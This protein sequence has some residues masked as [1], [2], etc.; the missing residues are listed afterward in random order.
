M[1]T[2]APIEIRMQDLIDQNE[3]RELIYRYCRSIDRC[4]KQALRSFYHPDAIEKHGVF[5][6]NALEFCD[7]VIEALSS[8]ERCMHCVSNIIINIDGDTANAESYV[9]GY[10]F[11]KK[12]DDSIHEMVIAGRYLDQ[13]QRRD[14]EWKFSE[15]LYVMD[16]NRNQAATAEWD[17]GIFA[18]L[19]TRG[20]R[21]PEDP[22]YNYLSINS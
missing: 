2:N 14:G 19:A 22:V 15:R 11:V 7:F 17:E 3:I 6:G 12:E 9:V 4:D 13:L 18:E 1:K 5:N 21:F 20:E 8:M 10:H 16:W